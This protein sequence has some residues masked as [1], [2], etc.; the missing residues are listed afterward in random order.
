MPM[1]DAN[2]L[3]SLFLFKDGENKGFLKLINYHDAFNGVDGDDIMF[4][5]KV[6]KRRDNENETLKLINE[7]YGLCSNKSDIDADVKALVDKLYDAI[8][9]DVE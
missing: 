5:A 7:L 8:G 3:K 6:F 1:I 9:G 4:I 2:T